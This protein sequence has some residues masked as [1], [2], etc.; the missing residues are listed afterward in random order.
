MRGELPT[1]KLEEIGSKIPKLSP[2]ILLALSGPGSHI[3]DMR[4]G[5]HVGEALVA[6]TDAANRF[7]NTTLA[8]SEGYACVTWYREL[9]EKAPDT[10][11]AAHTGK[12]YADCAALQLY[13]AAEDIAAFIIFFGDAE[14]DFKLYLAD[15]N[16]QKL[17]ETLKISS[18]AAKVGL[19]M[20]EKHPKD[21][22]TSLVLALNDDQA[23]KKIMS[24]RNTWTHRQPPLVE[25]LGI[26]YKRESPI[27]R[28]DQ[29]AF[30]PIGG[31]D[32]P[33]YCIH[34]LLDLVLQAFVA[35]ETLFLELVEIVTKY[36]E[37]N[38]E[39]SNFEA[40]TISMKL[41]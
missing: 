9:S 28:T 33:E 20:K 17:M 16:I 11:A 29:G 40:G 7:M 22:I 34:E 39:K 10:R 13:A 21:E 27:M 32:K 18:S 8:L 14:S 15:P 4:T 30:M 31:G 12:F 6:L 24:Y 35:F 25:G 38:G 26:Q 2:Q 37:A 23:W 3:Q 1:D 36:R 5:G 41:L 19:Y